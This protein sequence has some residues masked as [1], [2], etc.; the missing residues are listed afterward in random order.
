MSKKS[1]LRERKDRN[2][3]LRNENVAAAGV[4]IL[5]C[6]SLTS[7]PSAAYFPA[8]D[9]ESSLIIIEPTISY[10]TN[11]SP[12]KKLPPVSMFRLPAT[13]GTTMAVVG[14]LFGQLF[15]PTSGAVIT[16][17]ELAREADAARRE[18]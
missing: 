15:V 13:E 12:T 5:P 14:S 6:G 7:R 4:G 1:T 11:S 8:K 3:Q 10:P 2:F 9:F 17:N 16:L 18:R